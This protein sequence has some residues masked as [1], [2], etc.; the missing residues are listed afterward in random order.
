MRQPRFKVCNQFWEGKS[1]GIV[2]RDQNKIRRGRN[3]LG[4]KRGHSGAQSALDSAADGGV[5]GFLCDRVSDP[6]CASRVPLKTLNDK[7]A[8]TQPSAFCNG[9]KFGALFQCVHMRQLF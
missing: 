7:S 6:R 3:I 5:A 2:T 8:P 1:E 4:L 9:K